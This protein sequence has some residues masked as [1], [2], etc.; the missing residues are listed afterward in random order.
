[1]IIQ[2]SNVGATAVV[3]DM[4]FNMHVS[5]LFVVIVVIVVITVFISQ[6]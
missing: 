1:M 2:A 3:G 4:Q 6:N 5:L